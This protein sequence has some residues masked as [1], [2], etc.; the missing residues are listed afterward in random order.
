MFPPFPPHPGKQFSNSSER[1]RSLLSFFLRMWCYLCKR[2]NHLPSEIKFTNPLSCI[3]F[4]VDETLLGREEKGVS[5]PLGLVLRIGSLNNHVTE[6]AEPLVLDDCSSSE[7]I[8]PARWAFT[9][10]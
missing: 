8:S 5:P 6:V 1:Q 3:F 7:Q 10:L 4:N 9:G 2:K